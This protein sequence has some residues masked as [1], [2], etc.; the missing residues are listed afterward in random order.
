MKEKIVKSEYVPSP[1]A[2]KYLLE[3]EDG[4]RIFC[5]VNFNKELSNMLHYIK[6]PFFIESKEDIIFEYS[7]NKVLEYK[8]YGVKYGI[9]QNDVDKITISIESFSLPELFKY[10]V[11][12]KKL[13]YT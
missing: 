13:D 9:N 10:E 6:T 3:T 8:C 11:S 2:N 12:F 4:K 5:Y 7:S 1:E